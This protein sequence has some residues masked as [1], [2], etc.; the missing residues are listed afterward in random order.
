MKNRVQ[1]E[2]NVTSHPESS[3][4]ADDGS[5]CR[6]IN[7][8]ADVR[9]DADVAAGIDNDSTLTT[10]VRAHKSLSKQSAAYY[11]VL[12]VYSQQRQFFQND[13]IHIMSTNILKV[14]LSRWE[15]LR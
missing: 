11:P 12:Q 15:K 6:G 5:F 7:W 3:S 8:H 9:I 13:D 4:E 10:P 2:E 14:T 1:K